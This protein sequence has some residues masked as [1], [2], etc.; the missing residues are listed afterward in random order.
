M[1]KICPKCGTRN[2]NFSFWCSE[3]D[4]RLIDNNEIKKEFLKEI[5]KPKPKHVD[6][7]DLPYSDSLKRK[8]VF[9]SMIKIPLVLVFV[10][11]LVF[12]GYYFVAGIGETNFNWDDYGGCPWDA[13]NL[14]WQ[15]SD[16][17]WFEMLTF[18]DVFNSVTTSQSFVDVGEINDDYWFEGDSIKTSNGWT[19]SITKVQDFS[20]TAK[21]LGYQIYNK[22]DLM[23]NPTEYFSPIDLFLGFDDIIDHPEKYPYTILNYHY[24]GVLV[25]VEGSAY[26]MDHYT[27]TH[28]IP[29]SA[30][31]LNTLKTISL[32]DVVTM[33]GY[34]VSLYGSH[35]NGQ[36]GSWTTDTVIGNDN[37]EIV[38][39]DS[40][41]K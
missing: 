38:L 24:R 10:G 27:N 9:S 1:V 8:D 20:Y 4:T 13:D 16:L 18:E 19:F 32:G 31:V 36:S 7:Y 5:D 28:I 23:F 3:C 37:C 12:A 34:Y 6:S 11:V 21:V 2:D 17:S 15:N 14:P 30:S 22:G 40:I 26:F 33:S 41:S 29:H 39:L 25:N 35:S